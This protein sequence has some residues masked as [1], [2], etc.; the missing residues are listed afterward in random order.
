M[1]RATLRLLARAD[2][3]IRSTARRLRGN[4]AVLDRLDR[5]SA[6]YEADGSGFVRPMSHQSPVLDA[7]DECQSGRADYVPSWAVPEDKKR[8]PRSPR[9]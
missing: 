7:L 3:L 5:L 9:G 6:D 4:R 2:E 1:K 8:R